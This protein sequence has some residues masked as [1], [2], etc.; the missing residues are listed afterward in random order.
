[1]TTQTCNATTRNLSDVS[2][3]SNILQACQH[4]PGS[5]TCSCGAVGM[6]GLW[7]YGWPN[8]YTPHRNANTSSPAV[9][10][11]A[12][13]SNV[14]VNTTG[15]HGEIRGCCRLVVW[16]QYSKLTTDVSWDV[17]N[18]SL[19]QTT[20]SLSQTGCE[21][22]IRSNLS[23]KDCFRAHE[24]V[25][26]KNVKTIPI[27]TIRSVTER[28]VRTNAQHDRDKE[29][30]LWLRSSCDRFDRNEQDTRP[31]QRTEDLSANER[32][33]IRCDSV[34]VTFGLLTGLGCVETVGEYPR[35]RHPLYNHKQSLSDVPENQIVEAHTL[36]AI[37]QTHP[38]IP[39]NQ[40]MVG[41]C[42]WSYDE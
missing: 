6:A 42:L 3:R 33:E 18:A 16:S 11:S 35:W 40:G 15:H 2:L 25:Y 39:G 41:G 38:W 34:D 19:N 7:A 12:V 30:V 13:K 27:P 26:W 9:Q 22:S 1:M 24:R 21:C 8:R 37:S 31:S 10:C 32:R 29:H 28:S 17:W 5:S 20:S 23:L 36:T 4:L 14:S